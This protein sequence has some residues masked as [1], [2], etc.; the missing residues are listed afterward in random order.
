M[1]CKSLCMVGG[2]TEVANDSRGGCTKTLFCFTMAT[3]VFRR[4]IAQEGFLSLYK[5]V[6]PRIFRLGLG[7]GVMM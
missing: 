4:I 2:L 1:A 5:G 3:H 7:G 6:K